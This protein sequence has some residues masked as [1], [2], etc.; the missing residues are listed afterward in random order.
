M[1]YCTDA[2]VRDLC[3]LIDLTEISIPE[4]AGFIAK[5]EARINAA[6]KERYKVPLVVPIPD[7]IQGI[8]ADMA[9][10]FVLDKQYSDRTKDQTSL[11]EVY[12][13]RAE[14]DLRNVVDKN[15]LEGLPGI[16]EV[17]Q[18]QAPTRTTIGSTTG[19]SYVSPIQEALEE[20]G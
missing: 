3:K 13:K 18:P 20:L 4:V 16:E 5:A 17:P 2:Q 14:R 7:L 10:S 6:L 9:A 1:P 11:A 15:Q 19:T 8:A 12:F